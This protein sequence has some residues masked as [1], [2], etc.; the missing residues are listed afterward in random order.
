MLTA[1]VLYQR[2]VDHS[3]AGRHAAARRA[4]DS[5]AARAN[6]PD[7]GAQI[8]GTL[9][10]LE[11]ETGDS[12]RGLELC[13]EALA[14]TGISPYTRAVLTS[15][16]GLIAMR[17]GD[18]DAAIG[19]L[20]SAI[21]QLAS[22]PRR[23]G[24]A[25][26]NRG[27]VYLQRGEVTKAEADF[28]VAAQ[29]FLGGDEPVEYA[30]ARH[31]QGYAA[32]L[33]GDII[34]ALHLMDEARPVLA[35]LSPVALA[36]C[37]QDRAEVLLAAGMTTEATALLASVARTYGSRRLR[38]AQAEAELLLARILVLE[39]PRAA[40]SVAR[41]AS[42]RFR[43]RG[44]E[45]WALRADA[46]VE[47]AAV[48]DGRHGTKIADDLTA[49]ADALDARGLHGESL[50]LRLQLAR[51]ALREGSVGDALAILRRSRVSPRAPIATR[52]LGRE[53]RAEV[54]LARS[55]P[56]DALEQVRGG[57]DELGD[58]LATFGSLDLRSTIVV[59]GRELVARGIRTALATGD[60]ETIFE[61]SER[62]RGLASRAVP[63]RPPASE[64][65]AADLAELRQLRALDP[66]PAS[67]DGR[68][69]AMLTDRIRRRQWSSRGSGTTARLASMVELQ[70]EL[71]P[72]AA[73]LVAYIWS[74]ERLT[75]MVVGPESAHVVDL[76]DWAAIGEILDG[77]PADL[78]MAASHL[79]PAMRTS[80]LGTLT[81]RLGRLSAVLV[82][83]ILPLLGDGR[84]VITPPAALS[85][86]PWSMLPAFAGRPL[87]LPLSAS[88][89]LEQRKTTARLAVPGFAAG[90]R[91]PRAEQEVR[92]AAASWGSSDLLVGDR[93]V[94]R[95]VAEL[96]V[97]VDV[98]HISAHGR[99][100]ADNPLFS[101]IELADGPL[102]GYDIDELDRVP[103]VVIL[104]AC[105]LG[106]S[107]VRWGQEA[108][109]MAPAWLSAGARCVIAA[110]ASVNDEVA[111]ELLSA[112]HALLAEG[113][114]PSD[115]LAASAQSLG[116][117][118]A[119][120]C[121]GSGW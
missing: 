113:T 65:G 52:L 30:K 80:V 83:P 10:Y 62:T 26:L 5:A 13:R 68:R 92:D 34:G 32:L 85:G 76:G 90:P 95:A 23:L 51:V 77:M 20:G 47:S 81:A 121:Y 94:A 4:L 17:R 100:S 12:E 11:S 114:S 53:I 35:E 38:Q 18:T 29:A 99:H 78:D 107:S 44:S 116:V 21:N 7:L 49:T 2:G 75:A 72:S 67:A 73:V 74:V 93:A 27:D 31:N 119:F 56:S 108:I 1:S 42:R 39:D 50:P 24:R 86:V 45:S 101:G 120:Q 117:S 41:T 57:L 22:D 79:S 105:E 9:A 43:A 89:W 36:V 69:E 63:L 87:T 110:P 66:A 96:A 84:V 106:R 70:A 109:G 28:D 14:T 112:T 91:V 48:A 16:L 54:A 97:R 19:W 40:M 111:R 6:D 103:S 33:A 64:Q 15:Q 115:A 8:A 58:W 98:L 71:A 60:P 25:S 118:A 59:H 104:S 61:W 82:E 102:Y 88:R 46:V 55:R 37:D 3:N